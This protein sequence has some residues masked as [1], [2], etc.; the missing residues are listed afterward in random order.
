M[1]DFH[2][3]NDRYFQMQKLNCKEYII[4]FIESIFPLRTDSRVLE[5]GCGEAGVLN[6]FLDRGCEGVGVELN[7][8]KL[9]K[10][11]LRL[12][13]YLVSGQLK[14]ISKDIYLVDPETEFAG[15]FDVIVLKDVIEHIFRQ[16]ELLLRIKS[17]LNPGGV[18]FIA[19]PPWQMPVG[20]HQ[21]MCRS[22][23]LSHWPYFHLLPMPVYK[24]ILKA[25]DQVSD[26]LVEI[27]E[28]G[29][30]IERFERITKKTGYRIIN[31]CDY[32][33]NPIYKYKFNMKVR[34]QGRMRRAIPYLRNFFTTSVFYLLRSQ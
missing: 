3:D 8:M 10:C 15:K 4:P 18:V 9:N 23:L 22:R 13:D 30:S 27:K 33:I 11:S 16:D 12:S 31:K 24:A 14:L 32:L 21:Q 34:K 25:F 19:F 7:A 2:L 28:T 29:I 20:G 1:Y 26:E 5:I 6:A 17:F